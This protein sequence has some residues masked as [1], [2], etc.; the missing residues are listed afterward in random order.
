MP[1]KYAC[2]L[3]AGESSRSVEII[4]IFLLASVGVFH[5]L[6]IVWEV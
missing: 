4:E 3:L 6:E 1:K 5:L 2:Y